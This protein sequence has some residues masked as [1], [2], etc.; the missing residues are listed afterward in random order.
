MR[1]VGSTDEAGWENKNAKHPRGGCVRRSTAGE[2]R[3]L[4]DFEQ[5]VRV[6]QVGGPGRR[7]GRGAGTGRCAGGRRRRRGGCGD[8]LFFRTRGDGLHRLGAPGRGD[9]DRDAE[10][11]PPLAHGDVE[12]KGADRRVTI[13]NIKKNTR[14]L[15]TQQNAKFKLTRI[16]KQNNLTTTTT[17]LFDQPVKEGRLTIPSIK[18]NTRFLQTQQN[19]KVKLTRINR[20]ND[21]TSDDNATLRPTRERRKTDNS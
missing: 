17:R 1:R 3:V 5:R 21:F 14:F 13:P 20:H 4:H 7:V 10:F 8:G 16:N 12:A 9:D 6:F 18:K 15:Q 19:E 11:V 2:R